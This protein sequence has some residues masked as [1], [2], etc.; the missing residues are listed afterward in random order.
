MRETLKQMTRRAELLGVAHNVRNSWAG[1][2]L[3]D[4]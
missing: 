2:E 4:A 3:P 1:A